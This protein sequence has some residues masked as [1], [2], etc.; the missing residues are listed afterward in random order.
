MSVAEKL[1]LTATP[2]SATCAT[3]SR[4]GVPRLEFCLSLY[5]RPSF[6]LLILVTNLISLFGLF[7]S[8]IMASWAG[9]KGVE[10]EL[11]CLFFF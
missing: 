11:I 3:S 9:V 4:R 5:G 6:L 1:P 8:S 10:G 2:A 7:T